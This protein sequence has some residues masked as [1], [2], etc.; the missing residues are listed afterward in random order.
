MD[1]ILEYLTTTYPQFTWHSGIPLPARTWIVNLKDSV[2][3]LTYNNL[4]FTETLKQ[5]NITIYQKD[6]ETDMFTK[7][8]LYI[9]SL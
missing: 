4:K 5:N 1:T 6:I 7:T 3:I 8:E 2:Y 9:S